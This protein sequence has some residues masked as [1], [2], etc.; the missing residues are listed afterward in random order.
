MDQQYPRP[1]KNYRDPLGNRHDAEEPDEVRTQSEPYKGLVKFA[2]YLL[3]LLLV[4]FLVLDSLSIAIQ[5]ATSSLISQH[6]QEPGTQTI[7]LAL[8]QSVSVFLLITAFTGIWIGRDLLRAKKTIRELRAQRAAQPVEDTASP[9]ATTMP[10]TE[11]ELARVQKQLDQQR[12]FLKKI[13]SQM[14]EDTV[15]PRHDFVSFRALYVVGPDGDIQ[16]EKEV[17]LTSQELEVHFWRFYA[18]GEQFAQPLADETDMELEVRALDDGRTECIPLLVDNKPTRKEFTVNFLPAITPGT[19]R[20]FLLKYKWPGFLR[21]FVHT[22][23]THYFWDSKAFTN[24]GVADFAVEWRFDPSYGDVQCESTR[25]KPSGLSLDKTHRHPG[26]KW[27][28]AGSGIPLGNIP[29]EL[30]FSTERA[31]NGS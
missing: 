26:T 18:N 9:S 11:Q 13:Q 17:I 30:S 10:T 27:V 20:A 5:H 15:R 4:L 2:A 31:A 28:Y 22:G 14:Y 23:R 7:S 8:A 24:G 3:C 6:P 1:D 12:T 19:Q 25:A 16:V 21:E 29:L